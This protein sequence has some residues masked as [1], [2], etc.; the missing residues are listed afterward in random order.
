MQ[1]RKPSKYWSL[2]TNCRK[3]ANKC[4]SKSEMYQRF[5]SAYLV[6]IKNGWIDEFFPE[7]ATKRGKKS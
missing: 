2:K 7:S 6:S 4:K 5:N 1:E 3:V